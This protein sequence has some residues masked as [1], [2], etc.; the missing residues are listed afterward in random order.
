MGW[1][2]GVNETFSDTADALRKIFFGYTEEEAKAVKETG[3]ELKE[4]IE[5]ENRTGNTNPLN[6]ITGTLSAPSR[7][8]IYS[9]ALF[10]L[11]I[12]IFRR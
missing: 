1:F 9:V 10:A 4:H 7:D 2:D 8:F 3:K 11:L 6:D 12:L 5:E